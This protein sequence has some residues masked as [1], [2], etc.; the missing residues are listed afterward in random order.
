MTI[1][2]KDFLSFVSVKE[3]LDKNSVR[4]CRNKVG[5]INIALE[6][7]EL[8]KQFVEEFFLSLM[9]IG[10][11]NNTLN[12]YRFAFRHIVNYCKDR[13]LPADFFDGFKSFDKDKPDIIILTLEEIERIINTKLTYGKFRGKD[14]NFLDFR[15]R[16]LTQFLAFTG[17]RYSEA[18]NLTVKHLDISAGKVQFVDTKTNENRTSYFTGQLKENLAELVKDR[19]P[20]ERVFRN[21]METLVQVTD[22]SADLKRRAV[23]AGITKR[24]HPHVFRHSWAT[25]MLEAGVPETQV[26]SLCGW[27][28]IQTL[29]STYMHL[30][31]RTLEKASRRF[32]LV[33]RSIEP[34]ELIKIVK[35]TIENLHLDEDS[36]L[37]YQINQTENIKCTPLSRQ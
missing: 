34:N 7:R 31:N 15:F 9:Q 11:K 2:E 35:E 19:K 6:N 13:G 37:S 20:D 30:A 32:P 27:K 18:G 3:G 5:L 21:S 8:N 14:S 24:V 36:R 29:Y 1:D 26:A 25:H 16:T 28:D 10:R 33:R 23:A 17:C 12:S 4:L 22:Y